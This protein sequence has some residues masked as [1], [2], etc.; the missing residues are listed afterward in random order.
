MEIVTGTGINSEPEL[1]TGYLKGTEVSKKAEDA[2]M[3]ETEHTARKVYGRMMA[4]RNLMKTEDFVEECRALVFTSKGNF[5]ESR[6]KAATWIGN[7]CKYVALN[8][9]GQ[10]KKRSQREMSYEAFFE[11][12]EEVASNQS[13]S[14]AEASDR[15]KCLYAN[16]PSREEEI[17]TREWVQEHLN[18]LTE[19]QRQAVR[20]KYCEGYSVKEIAEKMNVHDTTVNNWLARGRNTLAK[21]EGPAQAGPS[22]FLFF[23]FKYEFHYRRKSNKIEKTSI[24]RKGRNHE[25]KS[26]KI[27]ELNHNDSRLVHADPPDICDHIYHDR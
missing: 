21:M 13:R 27:H 24:D 19:N 10:I 12:S 23:Y 4:G 18:C 15:N 3:R 11:E 6:S 1:I 14:K 25:N 5:D 20:M 26:H 17:I 22:V 16:V 2:C 8:A 9:R 7:V